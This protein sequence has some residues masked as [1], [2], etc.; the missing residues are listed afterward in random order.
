MRKTLLTSGC[1]MIVGAACATTVMFAI[2]AGPA[3]AVFAKPTPDE[4]RLAALRVH[5]EA[6][7]SSLNDAQSVMEFW[8]RESTLQDSDLSRLSSYTPGDV[9]GPIFF[10]RA[11]QLAHR[12]ALA[13]QDARLKHFTAIKKVALIKGAMIVP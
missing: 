8:D 13:T 6:A 4:Q 11:K 7:E 10:D 2:G 3:P 1:S 12:A 9:V 5:L